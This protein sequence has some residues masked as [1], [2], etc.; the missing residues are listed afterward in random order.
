M[1]KIIN[2]N[3]ICRNMTP[4][5]L[6]SYL[7]GVKHLRQ[8]IFIK[9]D[10]IL[11]MDIKHI[12]YQDFLDRFIQNN[13]NLMIVGDCGI[14]KTTLLQDMAFYCLNSTTSLA[15]WINAKDLRSGESLENYLQQV[16]LKQAVFDSNGLKDDW[17][18]QFLLGKVWL[19]IDNADCLAKE[20]FNDL[21]QW[22]AS[23]RI[24]AT[25]R[26]TYLWQ[27]FKICR[28]Q[29]FNLQQIQD[30]AIKWFTW[31]TGCYNAKMVHLSSP[32]LADLTDE[33]KLLLDLA[34][35]PLALTLLCLD[36]EQDGHFLSET[37]K[38]II[39]KIANWNSLNKGASSCR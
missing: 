11:G 16:W 17:K 15:V 33:N 38:S 2:W 10:L 21:P 3:G 27:N 28:I 22:I 30:F 8:D 37:R 34:S 39:K 32:F 14:G 31:K 13:E 1:S 29:K 18:Q 35:N 6:S 24:I 25:S 5:G 19:M 20:I 26:Q 12:L 4:G 23:A 7:L 36:W 9:P